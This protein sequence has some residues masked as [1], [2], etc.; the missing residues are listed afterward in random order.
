MSELLRCVSADN[1]VKFEGQSAYDSDYHAHPLEKR[2]PMSPAPAPRNAAKFDGTS[3]YH[4]R[5]LVLMMV[6][7]LCSSAFIK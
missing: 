2:A 3:T 6:P 5:Y 1:G 4:V 7:C